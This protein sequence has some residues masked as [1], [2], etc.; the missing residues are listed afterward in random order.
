MKERDFGRLGHIVPFGGY[1][2]AKPEEANAD[3]QKTTWRQLQVTEEGRPVA[4]RM[5]RER[6]HCRRLRRAHR[7][8]ETV[9]RT[10]WK[11]PGSE[12]Q[13]ATARG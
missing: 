8:K 6:V 2:L 13:V 1:P 3:D 11:L 12:K 7:H 5:S 10:D 9:V 4:L